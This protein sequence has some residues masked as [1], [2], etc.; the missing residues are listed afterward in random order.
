MVLTFSLLLISSIFQLGLCEASTELEPL[1]I[2]VEADEEYLYGYMKWPWA[3][4]WDVEGGT[5]EPFLE[6]PE[7]REGDKVIYDSGW[8]IHKADLTD[9]R[10]FLRI[11]LQEETV[12]G[13][14]EGYMQK[15]VSYPCTAECPSGWGR[16][17]E[18]GTFEGWFYAS[19]DSV[20]IVQTYPTN[21]EVNNTISTTL[22]YYAK[23]R[24]S[25]QHEDT[26]E[27][28]K[29]I[30]EQVPLVVSLYIDGEEVYVDL[31]FQYQDLTDLSTHTL[32]L[33][34][35]FP[36]GPCPAARIV[37]W[38][39]INLLSI[40]GPNSID[41]TMYQAVFGLVE[42]GEGVGDIDSVE[43]TFS[44]KNIQDEWVEL[45]TTGRDNVTDYVIR[46][47]GVA[48]NLDQWH[49]LTIEH[50]RSSEGYRTLEM[51]AYAEAIKDQNI[52]G[53]SDFFS[54]KYL[55]SEQVTITMWATA[56][57]KDIISTDPDSRVDPK[58]NEVTFVY[59]IEGEGKI[60]V[61]WIDWVL[62][63]T[64][65]SGEWV[66][67]EKITCAQEELCFYGLIVDRSA[68]M[69]ID[70]DY[71]FNL[72]E[73]VGV[74]VEDTKVLKMKVVAEGVSDREKVI[75]TSN[76]VEFNVEHYQRF[77]LTIPEAL[78][79][80]PLYDNFTFFTL[81]YGGTELSEDISYSIEGEIP[82]HLEII[83]GK[84]TDSIHSSHM[85]KNNLTTRVKW[86]LTGEK[87]PVEYKITVKAASGDYED[88]KEVTLRLLPATWSI[89]YYVAADTDP[90]LQI[91]EQQNILDVDDSIFAHR[92][93]KIAILVLF[94]LRNT[95]D[96]VLPRWCSESQR[97]VLFRGN[98]GNL[99]TSTQR[100]NV[101]WGLFPHGSIGPVNLGDPT[102]LQ[103][104]IMAKSVFI[105]SKYSQLII[106]DHGEGMT[107][108]V[109]DYH[110]HG[111]LQLNDLDEALSGSKF[112]IIAFDACLMAQIEVLYEIKDHA[113]YFVASEMTAHADGLAYDKFLPILMTNPDLSPLEYAK[114]IAETYRYETMSAIEASK[115]QPLMTSLKNLAKELREGYSDANEEYREAVHS[116]V[117]T[118]RRTDANKPYMDIG[119]F[120]LKILNEEDVLDG[121]IRESALEVNRTL[122]EAVVENNVNIFETS[123]STGKKEKV[124]SP[125]FHGLTMFFWKDSTTGKAE[126]Q[127]TG[128]MEHYDACN[129]AKETEWKKVMEDYRNYKPTDIISLILQHEGNELYLHVYDSEGRHIGYNSSN[130]SK[131]M[132][133]SYIPNSLYLDFG[134]GTDTIIIPAEVTNFEIEVDGS[135]MEEAEESYSLFIDYIQENEVIFEHRIDN[136]ITLN[137]SHSMSVEAS[138]QE[139]MISEISVRG[140][141]SIEPE[142]Q[143]EPEA[144]P[145]GIPG[146][147]LE[148]LTL[149]ILLT[150]LLWRIRR[151]A[152]I[153]I[154]HKNLPL[155]D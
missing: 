65:G 7:K 49:N 98:S 53:K 41:P 13:T 16:N 108:I 88:L 90:D 82:P 63:Y 105:P 60:F 141:T 73:S 154:S 147:P 52:A 131:K 110:Q 15:I 129:F 35:N 130:P 134:N 116:V 64:D 99:F 11:D 87:P 29:T 70:L 140:S 103:E 143:P 56:D 69:G 86:Q 12:S 91:Y 74:P 150:A 101:R 120:A 117:D 111:W 24:P 5:A 79:I 142:P 109:D 144:K 36:Y 46:A 71:W 6:W 2:E 119:D 30:H 75:A 23:V 61:S 54:F 3:F 55:I 48:P 77:N 32:V 107:G 135:Y 104:V 128:Y 47:D 138:G 66:E 97:S 45:G 118:T 26:C 148:A 124:E 67:L 93:P 152:R 112:N 115:V 80:Y 33:H 92:N 153:D 155:K 14:I 39:D 133:D 145:R 85:S 1:I 96:G 83:I 42:V 10:I 51:R 114:K 38:K 113:N 40:S 19:I 8:A 89:L 106:T 81:D 57:N 50:G 151:K 20:P 132:I 146:F 125:G 100:D 27:E 25:L 68:S 121:K 17:F 9:A 59:E 18:E 4:I 136:S 44:Y 122:H 31:R 137:S 78:D 28:T 95:W 84:S 58:T 76:S 139:L 34:S 126:T 62:F 149:G 72:A 102:K 43:W 21:W 127:Y 37:E 94:D 22:K 123:L